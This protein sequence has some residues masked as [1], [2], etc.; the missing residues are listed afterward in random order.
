[1]F[2]ILLVIPDLMLLT[3]CGDHYKNDYKDNSPTS[4]Q[5]RVYY[6][7]GLHLHV[8]NQVYTF[9]S[10]YPNAKIE[11][12]ATVENAAVQALFNDSCEAIVVSRL[13]NDTESKAFAS[14]QYF[15]DYSRVAYSGVA[16]ITNKHTNISRLSIEDVKKLTGGDGVLK[17]SAGNDIKVNV[18][19]D[20]NNSS[21]MH[22][23]AD[24]VLKGSLSQNC[25]VK[26]ST[27]LAIDYVSQN[28]NAVAFI[29]F[30]WLSDV[31]DPITKNAMQQIKYVPV[32]NEKTGRAEYPSQSSFKLGLYPFVRSVYVMRKVGDFT[33]AKGFESFVAGPKGQLTF[34]KQGLMPSRQAERVIE[35]NMGEAVQ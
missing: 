27:Q 5:L 15:P 24:S 30:A 35:V 21:V 17:D 34:L 16:V 19:F 10:Q 31:D 9:Q 22:Y 7:E 25:S 26:G 3:A 20:K 2:R 32:V 1:M 8:R 23:M 18:L 28:K 12:V 6:D 29:D 11:L 4:G 13:L 33:L 14:R